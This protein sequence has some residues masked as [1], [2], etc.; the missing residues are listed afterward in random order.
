MIALLLAAA[1]ALKPF[2]YKGFVSGSPIDPSRLE[3]CDESGPEECAGIIP[4]EQID[5][6]RPLLTSIFVYRAKLS[7]VSIMSDAIGFEHIVEAFKSKYGKPCATLLPM[8]TSRIGRPVP[9]PTLIWCFSGGKLTAK[10]HGAD[11]TVSEVEY[12]DLNQPPAKARK[13]KIDF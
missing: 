6:Y 1:A 2:D 9:N 4:D 11:L 13:P 7:S 10:M 12:R 8:W 5:G 3:R